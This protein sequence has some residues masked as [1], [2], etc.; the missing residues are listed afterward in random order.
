MY[1]DKTLG[2][3]NAVQTPSRLNRTH[4][5]KKETIVIDFANDAEEIWKS[6]EPYYE[7]TI[8][9]EATDPNLLYEIEN[10]LRQFEVFVNGDV[11][12]F[13]HVYFDPKATQD[14]IYAV[15]EPARQRFEKLTQEEKTDFRSQVSDYVRLTFDQKVE[16]VIQE[17]VDSNFELYKRITDD[18]VS[19]ESLKNLLF[20]IYLK[21][22]RQADEL[23][24]QR[25]SKTLEFKSTLRWNLKENREDRTIN[26]AAIKTI[27]AF[28]NTEGGDLLIGIADDRSVL[29]IDKDGFENEDKFMLHLSQMVRHTLGDR[30]GTY[31]DPRIQVVNGR[32]VCVV[33]CQRSPEP[34]FIKTKESPDAGKGDLYV[35]SGPGTIKLSAEDTDPYLATRFKR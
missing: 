15:L 19:G 18:R 14:R 25:E 29:G 30:A 31:I 3:V 24:K 4:P 21:N 8:L 32:T 13:A 22:H 6:F 20:D 27:A 9:S 2:G 5:E 17:I 28:L 10:R 1:V 23:L 16:D 35:R 11:T 34:V 7:T 12:A 26:C 33:A